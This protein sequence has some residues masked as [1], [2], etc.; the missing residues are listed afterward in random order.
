M[1]R[2]RYVLT[3]R[4]AADL[5]EARAWSRARWGNELTS[6]YFDD[7]HEGA[8]F[9]AENHSALRGRQELSGGTRLL[10]YPVREHYIV[11]EPLAERFIAVV[12]VIRQRRDVPA[13]LQKW[14]A[15]I[16]RELIEIRARVA[17]GEITRPR[18]SAVKPRRSPR[19]RSGRVATRQM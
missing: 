4:A 2:T 15:P 6:R 13:I 17:L 5:R 11:C 3:A 7:L 19:I 1:R 10:V 16:R 8:Q 14:S 12:A 9:I 18:Q